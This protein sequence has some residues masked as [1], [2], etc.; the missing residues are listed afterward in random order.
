[1]YVFA[2]RLSGRLTHLKVILV[3]HFATLGRLSKI[4]WH[5]LLM[6]MLFTVATHT[7]KTI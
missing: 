2:T 7:I 3:Y 5:M 6:I 4:P 1:M